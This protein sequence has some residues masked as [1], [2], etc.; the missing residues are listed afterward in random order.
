MSDPADVARLAKLSAMAASL[1]IPVGSFFADTEA[2]ERLA[3]ASEC[4]RLWD[5]IKTAEDR[6]R[7]LAY[8]RELADEPHP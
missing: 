4:A 1:G 6:H 7:A 2:T 8:L 5:R 3:G